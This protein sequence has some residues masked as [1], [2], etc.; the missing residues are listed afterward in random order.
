MEQRD[1]RRADNIAGHLDPAAPEVY[2]RLFSFMSQY[3]SFLA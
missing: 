3:V 1:E 2:I